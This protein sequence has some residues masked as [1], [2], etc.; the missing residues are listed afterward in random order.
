MSMIIR[1][2]ILCAMMMALLPEKNG[3]QELITNVYGRDI[4]LLNGKWNAIVDQYDQG[5]RMEIFKNR[6]P[7]GKTDFYEYSFECAR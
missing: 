7:E 5:V 2:I 3:A 1:T 4:K 6:K